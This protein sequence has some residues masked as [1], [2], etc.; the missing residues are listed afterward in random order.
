MQW[1]FTLIGGFLF[2]AAVGV[3]LTAA[4]R[5]GVTNRRARRWLLRAWIVLASAAAIAVA[6]TLAGPVPGAAAALGAALSRY[7]PRRL[8][9]SFSGETA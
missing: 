1:A 2:G 6:W 5:A 9:R 7:L 4:G 8:G 3:A